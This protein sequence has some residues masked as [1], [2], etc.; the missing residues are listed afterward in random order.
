MKRAVVKVFRRIQYLWRKR[1]FG[2]Y[3]PTSRTG[4][5]VKINNPKNLFMYQDTNI[6][7]DSVIMNTRAKFVLKQHSG[8]AVGLTVITGNHLSVLG[9]WF[10]SVT[11][12]DKDKLDPERKL[13]RDVV[14]DEDVWIGSHVTL[15]NGV[16]IGRGAEIG[17]G[18]VVRHN[19]PPYSVVVGNPAKVVGFKFTPEEIIEHEK[20]LYPEEDRLP[21]EL[22]E[23]NYEKYFLKRLKEIKAWTRL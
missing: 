1:T 11:N 13:D 16:H 15:L 14:V 2:H 5:N 19:I 12:E 20:A 23:K 8:A 18:S 9:K 4:R 10:K 17:S 7:A 3:E 21:I 6:D 22:L